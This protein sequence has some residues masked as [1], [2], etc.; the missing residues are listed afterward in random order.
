MQ[1]APGTRL[2]PYEILAPAGAGGMGEVYKASDT[3]LGRIV[4]LKV[5]KTE[6][7]ERFEREARAVAALNHSNIC[8]VHD[9]GPNYLVM[10]Y[11]EGA[12]L[13]GP[14][15]LDQALKYA[16]QICD[17]LDA[18]HRKGITHR[19]LKPANILVTKTGIKLLDF[20]LAKIAQPA[21]TPGDATLTMALT[22]KNEIV[23]TLYYMSPEQLQAQTTGQELDARSDIFSFG[24]VLYEMLTGKRAF[25]GA[26]PASVIAAIMERPAP[27][28]AAIAPPALDRLMQRCLKKDP[29]DRW[30]SARDLKH[31]LEWIAGGGAG[32]PIGAKSKSG[33]WRGRLGWIAAAML[34][35]VLLFLMQSSRSEHSDGGVVRLSIN[36]TDG[37]MAVFDMQATVPAPQ[38]A[39]SPDGRAV[40]FAAAPSEGHSMLWVRLLDEVTARR[41]PGTERG[42]NPFWSPDGRWIGF[43]SEG[44]IR[45]IPAGGGAVQVLASAGTPRGFSWG[46]DDT[47]LFASGNTGLY[48][49][50]STGG[51][52]T[53]VT[54]LDASR[55]EGSHRWPYF[56]PDGR[57]FL[58]GIRSGLAEQQGVYVGSL[59]GKVKKQL[60]LH[61]DTAAAYASPG[62]LLYVDGYTL[63]AQAFDA[64][65]L[66]LS[67]QPFIVAEQ[68]GHST[69]GY[70]SMS[71]SGAGILAYAGPILRAGQLTWFDREGRRSGTVDQEGEYLDF[72]LSPDEN[73]VAASLINPRSGDVDI[74]LSDIARGSTSRLTSGRLNLAAVWSPDGSR[75]VYRKAPRGTSE[76]FQR[77]ASG[78]GKDELL[79]SEEAQRAVIAEYNTSEPTDWSSDGRR[80]LYSISTSNSQLWMLPIPAAGGAAKPVRLID[81]PADLMHGNFS[82]DGRLIAYSSNESGTWEV[83]VQTFPLSDRKWLVST[84]GGYEPR[85]RGDGREIYY[86]SKDRKLMAVP[87][88]AGSSFGVPKMLF[89]TQA[90]YGVSAMNMHY[91]PSRD[92]RRFLVNA[93]IGEPAPNPITVVLNWTAALKK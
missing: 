15:P 20:G 24:I 85:W 90:P 31:E 59:D 62:Y 2:G 56:L 42:A 82:P 30:Q 53:E 58:Y 72:R 80:L 55:Q 28:I 84:N 76:I 45:K 54:K 51:P 61:L 21:M 63:L 26:S 7:S 48:R 11:I 22:G 93:Q 35:I 64:N 44:K 78:G 71:V 25:E 89:Q 14:L 33:P 19:D 86:L 13:K 60:L 52:V 91:V 70:S 8:T 40:V 68:V 37:S 17:A 9:V 1:L 87:V 92:G 10:E 57:H 23:G 36:P 32:V 75:I 88:V 49:V 65:S 74:W 50:A 77:S 69:V 46:S 12:Q 83:Y 39:V 27:S 4:A 3:R 73:R 29:D 38:F 79:L 6:F 18:A 41:L 43:V 81:S 5:S 16:A 47:I 34:A 66:E 67:G